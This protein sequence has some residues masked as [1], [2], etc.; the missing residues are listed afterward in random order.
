MELRVIPDFLPPPERLRF[1]ANA[2]RMTYESKRDSL[3]LRFS[4]ATVS[5]TFKAD[6]DVFLEYD[7]IGNLVGIEVRKAS[8]RVSNPQSLEFA[9]A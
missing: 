8:K 7:R 5:R 3:H 9:V 1:R 6:R 4:N 2:A